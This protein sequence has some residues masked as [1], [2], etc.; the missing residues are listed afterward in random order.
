M[1]E[2]ESTKRTNSDF[3]LASTFSCFCTHILSVN[4][5]DRVKRAFGSWHRH[6][7]FPLCHHCGWEGYLIF[8]A[9]SSNFFLQSIKSYLILPSL[10]CRQVLLFVICS[11]RLAQRRPSIYNS[12]RSTNH[13]ACRTY[14]VRT[15]TETSVSSHQPSK[16]ASPPAPR[17][18]L[19]FH[20]TPSC[21]SRHESTAP[22][23][24]RSQVEKVPSDPH[25][26][27]H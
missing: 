5:V 19:H 11:L 27:G 14:H 22:A 26:A 8:D 3:L 9:I 10:K 25:R 20:Q 21:M 16:P 1:P 23:E 6:T 13:K 12:M 17:R 4:M 18:P 24:A 7:A 2:W 15:R